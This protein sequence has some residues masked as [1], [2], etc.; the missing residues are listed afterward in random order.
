[1]AVVRCTS[2]REFCHPPGHPIP[3]HKVVMLGSRELGVPS[4]SFCDARLDLATF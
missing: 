4:V 1:M 3:T 2:G